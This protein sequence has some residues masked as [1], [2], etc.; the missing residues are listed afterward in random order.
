VED[1]SAITLINLIK[2]GEPQDDNEKRNNS[3]DTEAADGG[4][5]VFHFQ[6]FQNMYLVA[7]SSK[8][9]MPNDV[10]SSNS[11]QYSSLFRAQTSSAWGR[12]NYGGFP[13][14]FLFLSVSVPARPSMRTR[15]PV[16]NNRV[17]ARMLMRARLV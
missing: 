3:P 14:G 8:T 2:D 11:A 12:K 16:F 15:I 4:L 13:Q 9:K 5:V 6:P 1:D 17:T 7:C 10:G